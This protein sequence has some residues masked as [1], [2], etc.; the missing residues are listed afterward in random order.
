MRRA[1]VGEARAEIH[2][3]FSQLE[4]NLTGIRD[5]L[6]GVENLEGDKIAFLVVVENDS[7]FILVAF[8]NGYVV[9]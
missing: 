6:G 1:G 3:L 2:R 7:R 4:I 8:V 5:S 9:S